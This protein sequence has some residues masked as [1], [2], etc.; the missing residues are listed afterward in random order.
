MLRLC[1]IGYGRRM[2]NVL[3]TPARF[4]ADARVVALVDPRAA[5]LRASFSAAL[6]DTTIYESADV[7]EERVH[8]FLAIG[9]GD[10]PSRAPLAAGLPS[11]QLCLMTRDACRTHTYQ[12]YRL[13]VAASGAAT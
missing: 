7:M 12:E 9:R 10:G 2:R 5:E 1:V 13:P 3:A 8:D 6:N 4:R 11:A